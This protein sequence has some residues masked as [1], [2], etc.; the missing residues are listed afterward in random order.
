MALDFHLLQPSSLALLHG[1][2]AGPKHQRFWVRFFST[3]KPRCQNIDLSSQPVTLAGGSVFQRYVIQ[4]QI[5]YHSRRVGSLLFVLVLFLPELLSS[6]HHRHYL[7]GTRVS[8]LHSPGLLPPSYPFIIPYCSL[9]P[10]PQLP[11]EKS[12][13]DWWEDI[14]LPCV[15][16]AFPFHVHIQKVFWVSA[17]SH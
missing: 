8:I 6:K 5:C 17:T 4:C 16:A 13:R 1:Y 12:N 2:R 14:L 15:C 7:S 10:G 9:C 11:M 3:P